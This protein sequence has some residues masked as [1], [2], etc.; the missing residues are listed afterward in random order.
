MVTGFVHIGG[1]NYYF[2]ESGAMRTGWVM[3]DGHWRYYMPDGSAADGWVCSGG[4]WY[5]LDGSFMRTGWLCDP[6]DEV[7]YYLDDTTG[8]MR[9]GWVWMREMNA[10]KKCV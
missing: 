3:V 7:C 5:Y 9:T 6:A 2:D 10:G 8:A 1:E 4:K